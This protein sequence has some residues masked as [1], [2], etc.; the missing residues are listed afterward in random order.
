LNIDDFFI[1]GSPRNTEFIDIQWLQA[2]AAF[3]LHACCKKILIMKKCALIAVALFSMAAASAQRTPQ[4]GIKAGLNIADLKMPEGIGFETEPKLGMHVGLLAHIHLSKSVGIQPELV[5]SSQGMKTSIDDVAYDWNL[6]YINLPIMLQYMFNNGFRLEAGPQIGFLVNA[7]IKDN[8][9]STSIKDDL[10]GTDIGL[11][12]GLNYLT[13]SGF[14]IG[15]RLNLG[16][17]DVN[18]E[19]FEMKNRVG[20]ISV[21]Y[22][23]RHN[24]KA[25]SK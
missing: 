21:F 15:G 11:G 18:E 17:S 10:K 25:T 7:K 16:L 23:F 3:F 20:Q 5:Y 1:C 19:G 13:Y 24:H 22:M 8:T 9:G 12:V 14:G 4:F 2:T 6:N